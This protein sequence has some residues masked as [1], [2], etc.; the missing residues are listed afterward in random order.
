EQISTQFEPV[1]Q[2]I[3]SCL[4]QTGIQALQLI[5]Q[6]G[7]YAY[8]E[9]QGIIAVEQ[10]P[11]ESTAVTFSRDVPYWHYLESR[12]SC[13]GDCRLSSRLHLRLLGDNAVN[14]ELDKYINREL[15]N[16]LDFTA[17][18]AQGFTITMTGSPESRTI[19]GE[20]DVTFS[21]QLPVELRQGNA[22][23]KMEQ[24]VSPLGYNFK[25]LY[26]T[27]SQLADEMIS[28]SFLE[29]A[30]LTMIDS[31]DG[32]RGGTEGNN[33]PPLAQTDFSHRFSYWLLP[34]LRADLTNELA[35]IIPYSR[36]RDTPGYQDIPAATPLQ[37][38]VYGNFQFQP[39]APIPYQVRFHYL[40]W[41]PYLDFGQ[42][43]LLTPTTIGALPILSAII[44]PVQNYNFAYDLSYPV[45]VE[46]IDENVPLEF[47]GPY[48]FLFALEVNIRNNQPVDDST[49]N[50]LFSSDEPL[51]CN[52]R[53]WTNPAT[54]TVSD[55]AS[56]VPDAEV[57]FTVGGQR[58]PIGIT[59]SQGILEA[60]FP[61]AIGQ[62]DATKPGYFSSAQLFSPSQQSATILLQQLQT[63]N[64][65]AKKIP[66]R[67]PG[68]QPQ[69]AASLLES[70]EAV[71]SITRIGE[72]G[73]EEL[74]EAV[75]ISGSSQQ[76]ISLVPGTYQLSATLIRHLEQPYIIP[77]S[78]KKYDTLPFVPFAGDK[79]IDIPEL[80]FAESFPAGGLVFDESNAWSSQPSG[81]T[82]TIKVIGFEPSDFTI[83]D[84]LEQ[85][86]KID[87]YSLQYRQ[88]LLPEWSP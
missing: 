27:A 69:A 46:L 47:N 58:C 16:C 31:L 41:Q 25:A 24:F 88:Q 55:G 52:P 48:S 44:P 64:L 14:K 22:R 33:L 20:S 2:Y 28:S 4:R 65:Q 79:T 70:E 12:N 84:D 86:D 49:L 67:K 29:L 87:D 18:N 62:L 60:G 5:G 36:V 63:I 8:P 45:V 81:N 83:V 73:E 3:Q 34:D 19:I 77:A 7:G 32:T 56:P 40:S 50:I 82:L 53:Q 30:T 21:A 43:Q 15:A 76:S 23:Q 13:S 71:I 51:F 26:D 80:T 17:L 1:R 11:T 35:S 10:A 6:Q 42:G 57:T 59:N 85:L 74:N 68:W 66:F 38:G 75:I 9:E 39:A 37:Q 72:P 61:A 54:I 78:Q